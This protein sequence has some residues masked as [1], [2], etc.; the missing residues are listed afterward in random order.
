MVGSDEENVV[1]LLAG[2]VDLANG[3][4]GGSNTLD[5]GL[6]HTGMANHVRRS[7]VVHDEVELVLAKTLS[8][9]GTDGSGAHLGV[10]IVGGNPGRGD[11]V[12]NL[13][14]EL[15]LNT[16]V[17][18]ESDV[19]VLLSLSNVALLEVLLAEPLGQDVTHVLR[20]E[21]NRKGVVGLILGHGG[22]GD[23]LGVGEVGA[24]GAVV[25]TQEL[26][27]LTDT[28]RTVVEEEDGI[29]VYARLIL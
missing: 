18:E 17:E 25:V 3:L 29:I 5:G 28:V 20:G 15:L 21:G 19:S 13:A 11:H 24:R 10:K 23:V 14:G 26:S 9:L 8:H 7:E 27:D 1:V 4:I 6:V 16:S 2:L 12:A 22:E